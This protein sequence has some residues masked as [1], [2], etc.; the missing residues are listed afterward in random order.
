MG[1]AHLVVLLPLLDKSPP[2]RPVAI[3]RPSLMLFPGAPRLQETQK[4][5]SEWQQHGGGGG[6]VARLQ[7]HKE[8]QL[9][10]RVRA[11]KK[12]FSFLDCFVILRRT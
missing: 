4:P 9:Y 1:D 2:V 3:V 12:G 7:H 5:T 6:N 11:G 10:G 8:L